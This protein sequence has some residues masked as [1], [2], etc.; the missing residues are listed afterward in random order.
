MPYL[1]QAAPDARLPE[2]S[3]VPV[4]WKCFVRDKPGDYVLRE[5]QLAYQACVAAATELQQPVANIGATELK[6]ITRSKN[7]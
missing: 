6:G 4:L 5:A 2:P 7:V 3:P 1:Y